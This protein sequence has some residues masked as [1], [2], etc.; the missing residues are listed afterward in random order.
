MKM[1]KTKQIYIKELKH[2]SKRELL[3]DLQEKDLDKLLKYSIINKDNQTYQFNYVG[4]IIIDD[5]VINCYPK[6]FPEINEKSFKQVIKV[7]KK[8]DSLHDDFNYQNEELTDIS[9]N[10]VSMMIFFLE[11]YYE[12]GVYSNIQN[13]LEINGN[14][15][16]DWNRTINY[17][18]P[19]IKNKR[20]YYVELYTKYKID[21]LYNYFRLLHEYIITICSKKLE[22]LGLLELFDLTPVEISDKDQ[23]DFGELNFILEKLEKELNVEFN[24]HKIK[25]LKSMHTFL[26][27]KNSFSNENYLTLYGTS[28]YHVIWEEMCR[29]VFGDKLNWSLSDLNLK[30]S[31]TKL[32]DVIKKPQWIYKDIV[33][34]EADGTFIPDIVTFFKNQFIILDAKYYKLRFD[35]NHL[36]GQPGLE[37]ITKQYLY[38]LAYKEFINKYEFS[39]VKNAFLLPKFTG[40]IE[41]VGVAKLEILS[42]LGLEDIQV[43][44]LPADMINQHYLDNK[45]ISI[46]K[47]EFKKKSSTHLKADVRHKKM[48]KLM[49]NP[50]LED[51]PPRY[52]DMLL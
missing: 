23:V 16:I 52:L 12:Y 42:N 3:E 19:I 7:I 48:E 15:E 44:M 40:E 50:E 2:Y 20:P 26:S 43:I 5:L 1:K 33:T 25:L 41:N 29:K 9:F 14:G 39:G 32:I 22:K 34:H 49:K 38:E 28:I 4:V 51:L 47:L 24:S 13:I 36:S 30:D 11:D 10:L 27:E 31:K 21:D 45:K 46:E 37:S 17:T 35:E 8:Y 18:D 6:Y